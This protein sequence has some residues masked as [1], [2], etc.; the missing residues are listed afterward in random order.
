[1]ITIGMNYEIRE[2]KMEPFVKKFTLVLKAFER[3]PGHVNTHLYRDV[4]RENSYL[5]LSEWASQKAFDDFV[6]SEA[7]RQVTTW[8]KENILAT[9]PR[10]T[11]FGEGQTLSSSPIVAQVP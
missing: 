5:V 10:H 8:G 9:R 1:M 3:M 4:Y 11:T 2:G 7:F 6:G